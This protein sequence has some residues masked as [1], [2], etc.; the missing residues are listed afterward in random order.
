MLGF[1]PHQP[2][3][4]PMAAHLNRTPKHVATRTMTSFPWSGSQALEGDLESGLNGLKAA[5]HGDIAILGSGV[6]TRELVRLNLVD[7]FRLFL[8]PCYWALASG[9]SR[10]FQLLSAWS[11]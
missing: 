2:K 5:G 8:H 7:E 6:M 1:W 10:I 11:C 9:S 4:N 3:S